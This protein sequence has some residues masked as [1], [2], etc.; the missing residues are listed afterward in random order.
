M[1]AVQDIF[2]N[3]H[4]AVL[5]IVDMQNK[6]KPG[7]EHYQED[8]VTTSVMPGVIAATRRLR[9]QSHR[10]GV[11]VL[12]TQSLRTGNEPRVTVFGRAPK[13]MVGS[14][15]VEIMDELRPRPNDLVLPKFTSDPFYKTDLDAVLQ[16]L[17]PDPTQCYAILAGGSVNFCVYHA[18]MGF[19][20]RNYRVV[21]VSDAVYYH[22]S[23]AM[24][25]SLAQFSE[26]AYP[27][28]L[29]SHSSGVHFLK[30]K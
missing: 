18:A 6:L 24:D 21:V 22:T 11:Q 2:V 26:S 28:I 1:K 7:G 10:A 16:R 25:R 19:Y 5:L 4:N 3:R 14:W 30:E 20:L 27:S 23:E 12:Y 13:N 9:S 15:D 8:S 29:L 17:V